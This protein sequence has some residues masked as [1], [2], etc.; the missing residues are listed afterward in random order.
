MQNLPGQ[1][2][3]FE[4]IYQRTPRGLARLCVAALSGALFA[5]MAV[6]RRDGPIARE[7][8]YVF[9][10]CGLAIGLIG[11]SLLGMLE[12]REAAGQGPPLWWLLVRRVTLTFLQMLLLALFVFLMFLMY[13]IAKDNHLYGL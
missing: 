3:V 11:G 1:A 13:R 12:R 8:W 2:N 10:G 5:V 9:A 7:Y 4:R 6:L